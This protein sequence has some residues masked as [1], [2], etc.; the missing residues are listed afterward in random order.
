MTKRAIIIAEQVE[1]YN[2]KNEY[3]KLHYGQ[4]GWVGNETKHKANFLADSHPNELLTLDKEFIHI[5]FH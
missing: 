5:P 2:N 3:N 1:F 4:T